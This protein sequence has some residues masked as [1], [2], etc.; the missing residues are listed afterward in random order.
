MTSLLDNDCHDC[1]PDINIVECSPH[2]II[3]MI[4][5]SRNMSITFSTRREVVPLPSLIVR[6]SFGYPFLTPS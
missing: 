5:D 3:G 4:Y 2:L 1:K 6:E